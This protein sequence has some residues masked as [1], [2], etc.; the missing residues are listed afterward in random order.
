MHVNASAATGEHGPARLIE[1]PYVAGQGPHLAMVVV[2][3]KDKESLSS[4][5]AAYTKEGLGPFVK[6]LG[7]SETTAVSLPKFKVKS[8]LDLAEALGAMGM[9]RA[10]TGDADFSGISS[11]GRLQI[12]H[13]LHEAYVDVDEHGTEAAAATAVTLVYGAIISTPREFK[14][15]RSFLFFIRDTESGVVLFAGRVVD[16]ASP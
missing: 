14:V 8:H 9:R 15:D 10:F 7:P 6:A 16:P 5:E 13:V 3:P 11:E 1:L 4:V 2:V 12:S